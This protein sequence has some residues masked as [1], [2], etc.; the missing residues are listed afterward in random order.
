MEKVKNAID[1]VHVLSQKF[2]SLQILDYLGIHEIICLVKTNRTLYETTQTYLTLFP[3][4]CQFPKQL[5]KILMYY[6]NK[7][8]RVLSFMIKR[9]LTN[10]KFPLLYLQKLQFDD[11]DD[12]C[13]KWYPHKIWPD[14]TEIKEIMYKYD[15]VLQHLR[16]E[17]WFGDNDRCKCK[18]KLELSM[19]YEFSLEDNTDHKVVS[20]Y[21]FSFEDIYMASTENVQFIENDQIFWLDMDENFILY[22]YTDYESMTNEKYESLMKCELNKKTIL[23]TEFKCKTVE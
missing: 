6:T 2:G 19:F 7:D 23:F 3:E 4:E 11:D 1:P 21:I 16:K 14:N 22:I 17:T 9:F 13:T 18:K 15:W 10:K 8:A 5:Y 12:T 20:S